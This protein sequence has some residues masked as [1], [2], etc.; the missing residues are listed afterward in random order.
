MRAPANPRAP[1][2][3]L[4][5]PCCPPLGPQPADAPAPGTGARTAR[6]RAA[7]SRPRPPAVESW[8]E[9]CKLL[10]GLDMRCCLAALC[11][12]SQAPLLAAVLPLM[13][14]QASDEDATTA[15]SSG[16]EAFSGEMEMERG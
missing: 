3:A 11:S 4:T 8:W 6:T 13:P 16:M 15:R 2:E 5:P 9:L 7:R 1:L 10:P 14:W 12:G